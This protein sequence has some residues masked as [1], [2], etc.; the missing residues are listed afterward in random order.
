MRLRVRGRRGAGAA[1][2]L[3]LLAGPGRAQAPQEGPRSAVNPSLAE[4]LSRKIRAVEADLKAGRVPQQAVQVSE[5]ELNSYLA[6]QVKLPASLSGLDVRLERD[7][8]AARGLLDLDQLQDRSPNIPGLGGLA[9]LSG[10]VPVSIRGRLASE[11]GFGSV[12]LEEVRLGSIPIAPA[13]LGQVVAAATKS[14]ERPQ[15]FDILAPFRYPYSVRRVRLQAGR[16]FL[17]F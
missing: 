3:L 8:V 9:L 16:A 14:A 17:D 1:L 15:G 10:R 5:A 7:R 13:V 4:S 11:D 6:Y 12:E 2:T